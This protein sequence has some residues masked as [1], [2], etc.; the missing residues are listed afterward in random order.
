MLHARV[1]KVE[2]HEPDARTSGTLYFADVRYKPLGKPYS[3]SIRRTV[4]M[5]DDYSSR[6]Y[7]FEQDLAGGM[8]IP[9]FYGRGTRWYVLL[10]LKLMKGIDFWLRYSR[11]NRLEEG[12]AIIREE[13]KTQIRWE[14]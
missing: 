6:V 10:R 3:V 9:A 8:N 1:E 4:F 13:I 14:F 7:S 2:Y 11:D 12:E 5:T